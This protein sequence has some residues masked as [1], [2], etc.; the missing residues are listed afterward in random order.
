MNVERDGQDNGEKIR[1]VKVER[2]SQ[3][4]RRKIRQAKVERDTGKIMERKQG[5]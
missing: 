5:K 2:D 4:N 1:Q 3:D